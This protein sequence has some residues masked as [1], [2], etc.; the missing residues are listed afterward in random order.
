MLWLLLPALLGL[1]ALP[2]I[3]LL[4][5]G[6]KLEQRPEHR[7]ATFV[8][9]G[10]PVLALLG[11]SHTMGRIGA[12]WVTAL[13]AD[14][15]EWNLV[16][17]GINGETAQNVRERVPEV[18]AC[19][20]RQVILLV[21]TNDVIGG[22]HPDWTRM[23]LKSGAFA[24]EP[25]LEGFEADLSGLVDDL[26]GV[27]VALVSLPPLGRD[28]DSPAGVRLQEHDALVRAVAARHGCTLLDLHAALDAWH[29]RGPAQS[30]TVGAVVLRM[31]GALFRHHLLGQDWDA[32]AGGDAHVDGIHLSGRAGS[33]LGALVADH[34]RRAGVREA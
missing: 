25:T 26:E 10:R 30:W 14:L 7:P 1:L 24:A 33:E 9:D 12:D 19:A 13:A 15:P 6:R 3:L 20:P 21:G 31:Y 27:P 22:L 28:P 17:A 11:D 29:P 34:V 23:F 16:N 8:D 32:I 18:L 5:L 4:Y 2:M